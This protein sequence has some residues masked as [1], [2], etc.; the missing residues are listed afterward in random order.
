VGKPRIAGCKTIIILIDLDVAIELKSR[1]KGS[2]DLEEFNKK[3]MEGIFS[4]FISLLDF[5]HSRL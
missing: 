5:Y 2:M 3:E 4:K 1:D